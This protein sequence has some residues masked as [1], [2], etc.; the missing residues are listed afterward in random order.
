MARQEDSNSVE[1]LVEEYSARRINRREFFERAGA[2]GLTLSAAGAILAACGG[3][4]GTAATTSATSAPT[5]TT[6]GTTAAAVQPVKGGQLIEGYDRDFN[7]MDPVLT[8]WDDPAFVALYEYP[9]VRD[10]AGAYKAA[11]VDSWT[12]SQDLL[13]W[14]FKIRSG[15]KFQS[16]AP[17]DAQ[18]IA[19]NFNAFRD[20]KQ[21]QN[22]IF[23]PTVKNATA[24]DPTTV[25]VTMKAPFTAFPETLATENSMICNLAKRQALGKNYGATGADG[26]GPF[27]FGDFKPGT[28]VVVNRWAGYPG[29]NIPYITNKGPAYLDS[30]KWVPILE[31]GQRANEIEGGTVNVVKNPAPQDIDRLKGNSDLVTTSFPSLSNYFLGLNAQQTKLGFNDVNVRQAIS[32]AIDRESLAKSIYFG[33]AVATY[34]PIAP[35]FKWYD[36]GV[37]QFNQFDPEKAKSLL[38]AA[39]W[40]VGSDGI[41]VKNGQRLSFTNVSNDQY[42][43]TTAAVDQAIIPMLQNVGVEMKLNVPDAAAYFGTVAA[44]A[45]PKKA[46]TLDSWTFEWLW[47]SPVDLLIYFQAFPSTA[48]NGDIP[49]IAAAVKK[50]Q[51]APDVATLEAAARDFQLA[52]AEKLPEIPILTRNDTW[53]AEKKVMGYAPLQT[54]LYPFYNDV[55]IS[56]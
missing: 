10:P 11:L 1:N 51:T 34:G 36:K 24:S 44:A 49:E 46:L 33:Q 55:W 54:M 37:E 30:V 35:N 50:W 29:T 39:G 47:S 12:I 8:N 26:S 19:D 6:A 40:T 38:D 53:V 32:H 4:G 5:Q 15:L 14:T 21:G 52:W 23:W 7:K 9:V 20:P 18:V 13:T 16:G 17:L 28:E 56:S 48:W 3:G 2:L 27:T 31:A 41:R 22:A 42:Q 43:P 45:D 25:V